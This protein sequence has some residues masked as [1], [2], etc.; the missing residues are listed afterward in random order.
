[1]TDL[2]GNPGSFTIT[3]NLGHGDLNIDPDNSNTVNAATDGAVDVDN[4]NTA[5]VVDPILN[6]ISGSSV[7]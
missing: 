2:D 3:L 1:M 7:E 6:I 4:D 5:E